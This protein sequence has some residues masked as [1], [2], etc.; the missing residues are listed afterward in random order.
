MFVVKMLGGCG[1]K[2]TRGR[3][4]ISCANRMLT[5]VFLQNGARQGPQAAVPT[6]GRQAH[7]H[8]M[9]RDADVVLVAKVKQHKLCF[10]VENGS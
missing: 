1:L 2:T 5:M 7:D 4:G 3:A 10:G 8:A 6:T 9:A